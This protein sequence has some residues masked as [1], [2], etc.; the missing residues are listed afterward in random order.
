MGKHVFNIRNRLKG[1]RLIK[2]WRI[3]EE[4]GAVNL[5]QLSS[6]VP[7]D[8]NVESGGSKKVE[9]SGNGTLYIK[10]MN[11]SD[12]VHFTTPIG[13]YSYND[14]YNISVHKRGEGEWILLPKFQKKGSDD[15][16]SNVTIG[17]DEPGSSLNSL[18]MCMG[19]LSTGIF[20]CYIF[21]KLPTVVWGSALALSLIGTALAWKFGN[22]RETESDK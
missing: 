14:N 8:A 5:E 13:I 7:E 1:R 19:G 16:N 18:S 10:V 22:K 6:T 15:K 3:S 4:S 17:P 9:N 21:S 20:S 12:S 11:P 2:V